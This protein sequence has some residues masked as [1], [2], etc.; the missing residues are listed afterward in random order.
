MTSATILCSGCVSGRCVCRR[1]GRNE[2]TIRT[3]KQASVASCAWQDN[4]Y[5][6]GV[7]CRRANVSWVFNEARASMSEEGA[8]KDEKHEWDIIRLYPIRVN[9][10]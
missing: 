10:D 5:K 3:L 1:F 8:R 6:P 4:L 7:N 2:Q 9:Y